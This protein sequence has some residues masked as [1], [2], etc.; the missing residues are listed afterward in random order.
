MNQGQYVFT[1]LCSFLPKVKFD[2]FVKKYEGNKYIKSFTCWNH[3][4]VMLFGQI[5]NRESMRDL[6]TTLNAHKPKFNHLGFGKSISLSNLSKANEVREIRIFEDLANLMIKTARDKRSGKKDFFLDGNIYAFDSSTISLCLNTFWWTKLHHNKGGV[7]LHTL[8]DVKTDIPAFNIITDASIHD[9]KVMSMIPY[10]L[11]SYYIFDR[12][13]MD[14]K[15]LYDIHQSHSFFV[16]REKRKSKYAIEYDS[17]Y[18]NPETGIMADQ[19]ISFKG[20]KTQNQ[21]PEAIR[22]V[23][24]YD[25]ITNKTF[26]FY[27]N[28]TEITAEEVALLYKYR[29]RVELFYKWLKQHLKIKQFYGTTENA[30][31][32]QIYCAIIS[33]CLIAI[34]EHDLKLERDTYDV[35]RILSISLLDKTDV[36]KLFKNENDSNTYQNDRQ[37]NL[38]FFSGH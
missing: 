35:L 5:S 29:W 13:Y 38:N 1:Q 36:V 23:V 10:E 18:N 21:Y 22:R 14:T 8:F 19:H 24:F 32:I 26:V 7:K 4:L 25:K 34:I 3:L 6:I 30:V 20:I 11:G 33:Y 28:N 27:T 15:K 12:A 17:N 37:L 9:S 2:W 16:V 31:R